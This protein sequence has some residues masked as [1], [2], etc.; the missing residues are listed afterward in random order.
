MV[1]E[2]LQNDVKQRGTQREAGWAGT[3]GES[4]RQSGLGVPMQSSQERITLFNQIISSCMTSD[5]SGLGAPCLPPRSESISKFWAFLDCFA[6]A[7]NDVLTIK[8]RP[9]SGSEIPSVPL[10]MKTLDSA[11]A[12]R[13]WAIPCS[14]PPGAKPNDRIFPRCLSFKVICR[15]T[16]GP[17]L[18]HPLSIPSF[19][20]WSS[21]LPFSILQSVPSGA[22]PE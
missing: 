13:D 15:V 2:S 17:A 6:S 22:T 1:V 18:K 19:P 4:M 7:R 14:P 5:W 20:L 3:P 8:R 11:S 21:S 9:P 16:E 12:S 10:V